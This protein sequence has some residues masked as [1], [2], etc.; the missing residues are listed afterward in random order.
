MRPDPTV[1]AASPA[2]RARQGPAS[3]RPWPQR[4]PSDREPSIVPTAGDLPPDWPRIFESCL[5]R[6][7]AWRT[8]PNW[9]RAEWTREVRAQACCAVYVA[10][11]H[12]DTARGVPF[13]A[14]AHHRILTS[15]LTR[16][17]QE[18]AFASHCGDPETGDAAAI[19]V[20]DAP[21]TLMRREL[22]DCIGVSVRGPDRALLRALF[23]QGRSEATIARDRGISQ[24]AISRRKGTLLRELRRQLG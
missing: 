23:W 2:A 4:R 9:S 20:V 11:S 13:A 17:R 3:D 15:V 1:R 14:F 16:Y 12:Y 10:A 21:T 18:W 7:A 5:R 22:L 24:Q 8:P 6:I 19:Q